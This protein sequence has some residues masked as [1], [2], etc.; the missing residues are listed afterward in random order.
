MGESS[1]PRHRSGACWAASAE[2]LRC[3]VSPCDRLHPDYLRAVNA[4]AAAPWR[5]NIS[6]SSYSEPLI[7][8]G[9]G[10]G[11]A[12]ELAAFLAAAV[13]GGKRFGPVRVRGAQGR[14]CAHLGSPIAARLSFG[15]RFEA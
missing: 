7:P 2:G 11:G 9:I 10:D 15:Q 8:A 4:G 13:V 5:A 14:H 1:F 3:C 6:I 12:D